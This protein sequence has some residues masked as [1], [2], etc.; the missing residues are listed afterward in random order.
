MRHLRLLHTWVFFA[1]GLTSILATT[2]EATVAANRE[3]LPDA[4]TPAHY[5]LALSPDA[6]ALTFRGTVAITVDVKSSLR[7]IVLN[8]VG[9]DF[10]RITIDG[11][12]SMTGT[13]DPK[14]GRETLHA[15]GL[16]A[17]GRHIVSIQYHGK[18]GRSTLGFF[19]MD[20]AGA[21]GPHRTLATNFEPAAARQLLP[22]WDEPGRKASFT[23]TVDAPKDRMAIS[24]MPVAQTTPVSATMQRIR[25]AETPKMSTYLL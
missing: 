16:I 11:G 4:V 17:V 22:C 21:D 6:E 1:I 3:V 7:D 14:L 23:V 5:D 19:A 8:A 25:F 18:I 12:T 9:L 24:N 2:A 15:E 13:A 10:D 20:Y